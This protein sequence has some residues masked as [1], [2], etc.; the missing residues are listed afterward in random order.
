MTKKWNVLVMMV[1]A[2]SLVLSACSSKEDA[3]P[4]TPTKTE[5]PATPAPGDTTETGDQTD[6]LIK[7]ADMSKNPATATN[8]KDTLVI[9]TVAPKGVF[10]P[11]FAETSYD[12]Y[13]NRAI[14]DTFLQ[15]Q[16]DGTYKESLAEKIDVSTDGKVYTFHLKKGLKY[17]DG[18]PVT[19]KDYLFTLKMYLDKSYDGQS[20]VVSFNIKGGKEYHDGTSKDISGVKIIDDNTVEVT[21]T[22]ADALTK[23]N[24]GG[25]E[26]M[27]ESY[28][29][30]AYK[31]GDLNGVKALNEK[32]VGSGQY[33]LSGYKAGQEVDLV[34]NENFFN[35]APK[36]KNV[37]FKT[38]TDQTNVSLLQS[39]ETDMDNITVTE[40]NVEEL[41]NIG[42][43]D[44]NVLPTNGY[45]Y[46]AINHK[47]KKFQDQRVRQALAYGLNRK[48]IVSGVY[49][50]YADV[51]NIPQSKVSWSYTDE[52]ITHYDFD[53][54]KAKSLLDEAGWKVGAD[55]IRE[56]DGEK[57]KINF[58]ASADNPVVESLLPIMTKNYK[59]LGIDVVAETLDFNAI[60]DKKTKGDYDMFFAAWGLTPDPDNTVYIT[61]G[62]QNDYN[63]SNPKVDELMLKGKKELDIEKR[64]VIYKELYQEL[65]KDLPIIYM[66]QRR[67]MWTVNGRAQGFDISPYKD[68]SYSLYNVALQQ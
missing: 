25:I 56:K 13:V 20:D 41:K 49:G 17:S 51:I 23:A 31:Q 4:T 1:L 24:L 50:K 35:G 67:D 63:Y 16:T 46:I 21:V 3:A 66:Y 12:V 9:G 26:F 64:K 61:K 54:A 37:I 33:K 5:D 58:S 11:L 68:F 45:G 42:F 7:A 28:Y 60:M 14:F 6:G 2:S 19:V 62:A 53:T 27:P 15:V 18:S 65:N 52:G 36:I 10:N 38:T 34:A 39:G 47:E 43:L 59:E 22:E 32:P 57:F 29:G 48:D 55:G 30:K 44:M 40:D 8:R